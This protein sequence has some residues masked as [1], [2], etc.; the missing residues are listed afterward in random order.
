[1][2]TTGTRAPAEQ[3]HSAHTTHCGFF[4]T[5]ALPLGL[6]EERKVHVESEAEVRRQKCVKEKTSQTFDQIANRQ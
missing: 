3:A 5:F 6:P 1:M 4:W 2:K